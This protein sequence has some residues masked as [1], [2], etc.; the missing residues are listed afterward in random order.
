MS[1]AFSKG[2]AWYK[3]EQLE[4]D[5]L[6]ATVYFPFEKEHKDIWSEFFSDLIVKIGNSADSFFR[7]MLKD[8]SFDSFPHVIE[9]K[10]G[11]RKRDITYFRDF[12]E[13]I[14][15]FSSVSVLIA[16]GPDFY[17]VCFPFKD[18]ETKKTPNW[19]NS[20]NHVKHQWFDCMKE[21][22]LEN[23][24][25]ALAGLF[26]LNILHKQNQ[27]YLLEHTNVFTSDFPGSI[28]IG[29]YLEDSMIGIPRSVRNLHIRA[30]TPLFTHFL[31]VEKDID[32][33]PLM[34]DD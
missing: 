12:F 26:V 15:Q 16:K 4:R 5:F 20:Y 7:L 27:K 34:M 3:F 10:K 33:T 22:T 19:W 23:T 29:M 30:E 8:N 18:F 9:L 24:I 32:G 31:R 2:L 28:T 13:P 17:E 25:D 14:Y 21:A 11:R 1:N 6:E